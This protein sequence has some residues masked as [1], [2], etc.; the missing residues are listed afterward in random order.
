MIIIEDK[1]IVLRTKLVEVST[2]KGLQGKIDNFKSL[3]P[4]LSPMKFS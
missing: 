4:L 1:R 3:S 2:I